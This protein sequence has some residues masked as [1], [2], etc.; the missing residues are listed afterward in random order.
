MK[1]KVPNLSNLCT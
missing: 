1:Q